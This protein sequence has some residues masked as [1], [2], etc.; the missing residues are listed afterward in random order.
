MTIIKYVTVIIEQQPEAFLIKC[1]YCE[2]SGYSSGTCKV[3]SGAGKVMLRIPSDLYGDIGV[4]KCGYC[5]GSGYSSGRCK[6]CKGPGAVVA[7]FPR[8]MCSNCSGS[9]YSSGRCR[10]CD[11]YGSVAVNDLNEY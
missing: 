11:G 7:E 6:V 2:G 8:V 9:G 10:A 5:E 4:L 3:C 1:G